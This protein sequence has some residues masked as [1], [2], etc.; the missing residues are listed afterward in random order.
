MK[1]MVNPITAFQVRFD[2][3]YDPADGRQ[4]E[5]TQ[6]FQ[7]YCSKAWSGELRLNPAVVDPYRL[8]DGTQPIPHLKQQVA[9]LVQTFGQLT[10]EQEIERRHG[11]LWE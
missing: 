10:V 11:R 8:L 1:S 5:L 2:P 9:D 3:P 4:G 6:A 7:E